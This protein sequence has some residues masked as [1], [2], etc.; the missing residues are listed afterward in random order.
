MTRRSRG[1]RQSGR[2]Y[3]RT[4]RLNKL[5]Q[6]I[7][8]EELELIDDDRLELVTVIDVEVDAELT[9]ARLRYVVHDDDQE[10]LAAAALADHRVRLQGAIGRQ[11]RVRKVP[12]LVFEPDRVISSAA[13]IEA[14]LRDLPETRATDEPD[15]DGAPGGE[16]DEG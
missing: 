6:E 3:P 12:E 14:I 5:F 7:L 16:E 15:D 10:A 9:R 8:A 11:A 4:A 2:Q 1:A 13:R